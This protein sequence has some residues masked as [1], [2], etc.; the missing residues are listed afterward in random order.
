MEALRKAFEQMG[1]GMPSLPVSDAGSSVHSKSPKS[2]KSPKYPKFPKSPKFPPA[3]AE[4]ATRASSSRS[5]PSPSSPSSP[6]SSPLVPSRSRLEAPPLSRSLAAAAADPAYRFSRYPSY[7]SRPHEDEDDE[8]DESD[9]EKEDE[10]KE[11]KYDSFYAEFGKSL[12][13]GIIEDSTNK[14]KLAKLVRYETSK[15]EGKYIGLQEYVENMPESQE[16]IY[17]ITGENKDAVKDSPFIERLTRKG[18]EVVYMVD[19]LDEYVLNAIPEFD[20]VRLMS[21]TKE[22]IEIAESEAAKEK[23]NA[24]K[25][26][27]KPFGEW[28]SGKLGKKV[29]KVEVSNRLAQSPCVLVTSKYG[30]SANMERIMK[31]QTL[32][33]AEAQPWMKAQKI[34]EINPLHPLIKEMKKLSEESPDADKL[35]SAVDLL[36]DTAM[37]TSGFSVVD[38]KEFATNIHSV[39]GATLGVDSLEVDLEPEE[40]LESGDDDEEEEEEDDEEEEEEEEK[41]EGKDEL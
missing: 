29:S 21:V 1:I 36:F 26:E 3:A 40:P 25:E 41:S 31:A 30:W 11:C 7:R 16:H 39:I 32:G 27:F 38:P 33:N 8:D 4:A 20:G 18:I 9:E 19:P 28:L 14:K 13:L 24:L 5:P 2:P 34:L 22:D 37:L 12:K 35:Q 6:R 10:E 15:S 17:Y 23:A